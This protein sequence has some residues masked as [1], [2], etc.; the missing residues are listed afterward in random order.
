MA[1]AGQV[2]LGRSSRKTSSARFWFSALAAIQGVRLSRSPGLAE[3]VKV[4][5]SPLFRPIGGKAAPFGECA[6][7]QPLHRFRV[8]SC[9]WAR[10]QGQLGGPYR[11]RPPMT[12]DYKEEALGLF[13]LHLNE[14][15]S[16]LSWAFIAIHCF[17]LGGR[18]GTDSAEWFLSPT[19][20]ER[21]LQWRFGHRSC[22]K[23]LL[24]VG[25]WCQTC[26]LVWVGSAS[27]SSSL[28]ATRHATRHWRTGS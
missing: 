1:A 24:C 10:T 5:R 12:V 18:G 22:S 2:G 16:Y 11:H 3:E 27:S 7:G 19:C 26:A 15:K 8:H 28:R 6:T 25:L 4:L 14:G 13:L 17:A 21:G 9:T 20:E 23:R